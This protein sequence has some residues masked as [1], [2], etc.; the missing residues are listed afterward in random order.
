MPCRHRW[1]DFPLSV[2]QIRILVNFFHEPRV[3]LCGA[4]VTARPFSRGI[5]M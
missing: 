2:Q 5:C 4:T 1:A 3:L